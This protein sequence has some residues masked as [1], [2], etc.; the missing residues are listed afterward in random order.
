MN[1]AGTDNIDNANSSNIIFTII[2]TKLYV[3][4][5]T[6]SARNNQKFSKR[7]SKGFEIPV[8]WNEYKTKRE[9]KNTTNEYRHFQSSQ[10]LLEL[11]DCLF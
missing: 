2:D 8:Y 6:L 7:L 11:I 10:I 1:Q 5:V 4:V 9:N 3:P